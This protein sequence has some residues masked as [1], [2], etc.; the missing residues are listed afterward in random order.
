M[1]FLSA[2]DKILIRERDRK[3]RRNL[4]I[5]LCYATGRFCA[6]L[7]LLPVFL[8]HKGAVRIVLVWIRIKSVWKK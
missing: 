2:D 1:D 8:L 4:W 5:N 3:L 7:F 6:A